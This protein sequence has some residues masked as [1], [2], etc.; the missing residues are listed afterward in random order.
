[1]R[2]DKT[3]IPREF[4]EN[5]YFQEKK[6]LC[7]IARELGIG[8]WT[9][10][11]RAM[12]YGFEIRSVDQR[13]KDKSWLENSY[14]TQ[15]KTIETIAKELRCSYPT[16]VTWMRKFGI[17]VRR[18]GPLLGVKFSEEHKSKIA[19][20]SALHRHSEETKEKLSR[21]C[22]EKHKA[23]KGGRLVDRWGYVHIHCP[24]HPR[25]Y[26]GRPYIKEHRLVMEKHLGRYLYKHE[27][28]HH[29][30][31]IR[32]DNRLENLELWA[33]YQPSG[34]RVK[35]LVE[36]IAKYYRKEILKELKMSSDAL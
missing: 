16:V 23:W 17:A 34:Q 18:T 13:L 26:R 11:R 5:K 27:N 30:N 7:E 8:E 31:G 25:A 32:D 14:R 29:K 28:I 6:S 35:D 22:G 15:K 3:I 10:R 20:K 4:L 21:I 2:K 1:M 36:F 33:R 9:V 12:E 19:A 24:K